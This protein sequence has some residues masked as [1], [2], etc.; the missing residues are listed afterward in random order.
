MS[1]RPEIDLSINPFSQIVGER[2]DSK[3]E[4]IPMM[5]IDHLDMDKHWIGESLPS[6]SLSE[7]K[8]A[9]I[10]NSTGISQFPARAD[11]THDVA[12]R[13]AYYHHESKTMVPGGTFFNSWNLGSGF[14]I[15][16]PNEQVFVFPDTAIYLYLMH[17]NIVNTSGF[18]GGFAITEN[19]GGS[20]TFARS[21]I[22]FIL[23]GWGTSYSFSYA[24][25]HTPQAGDN[26]Q[27]SYEQSDVT[28][29]SVSIDNLTFHRLG[30]FSG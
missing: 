24:M 23:A 20:Q 13:S 28:N 9:G 22:K 15:L 17:G 14:N 16:D 12:F 8:T 3:F 1:D 19:W 11:H 21:M 27:F 4:Q 26:V 30:P 7:V 25:T 29:H 2:K 6:P 5:L 10:V 18:T